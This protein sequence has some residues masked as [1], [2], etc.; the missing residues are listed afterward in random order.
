MTYS[1]LSLDKA[2]GEKI[3]L[4]KKSRLLGTYIIGNTGPG[5]S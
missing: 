2:T 3:T 5:K 4:S 1:V